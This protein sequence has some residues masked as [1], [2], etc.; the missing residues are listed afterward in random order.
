MEASSTGFAAPDDVALVLHTSGTT[1]RPKI[2]PLTQRNICTSAFHTMTTLQLTAQD[3]CLNVMPLFHIHGLMAAVLATLTAGGTVV[4]SPGFQADQFFMWLD[5]FKPTWYTAVPTMHQMILQ[6]MGLHRE[7]MNNSSLRLIRSSSASLPVRVMK[8]LEDAFRAPVI[9]AYGMTEAAH[10]IASNPLP[11]QARKPGSVGIA[12]GPEVA[13]M[14]EL[15]NLL[16]AELTGE[17]VI[18]GINVTLGYENNPTANQAAFTNEWFRTG[19]QGVMDEDGYLRITGRIK[20]MINRGGEKVMPREVDEALLDHANVAQ[21]VAFAVPHPSLGEDLAAAV[22]LR[23]QSAGTTEKELRDYAFSRLTDFKVPSQILI[24]DEI[25]KGP[26]G[27]LQ[28]IGLADRLAT[29]LTKDYV[30]PTKVIQQDLA[31]IWGRVLGRDPIGIHNNFFALGGDSL[32]AAAVMAETSKQIG[33][34]L[35]PSMLFRAPTIEQLAQLIQDRAIDTDSYLV[36]IRLTGARKPLFLV[37]GHGGDVFTYVNMVRYLHPELPVYVFRFPDPARLDDKVANH[38]LWDMATLYIRE[39][40]KVQPEGPYHIGGFCYGGELAFEMAQQL[41]AQGQ[42]TAYLAII[43]VYLQ[44]SI[45]AS[46]LR[47]RL[48]HHIGLFMRRNLRGKAVYAAKVAIHVFERVSR[49]FAPR[50]TRHLVPPPA[51]RTYFPRYY[52]G[53]F[54]LF[55]PTDDR[56]EGVTYSSDMGWTGLA[57]EINTYEIPGTRY[58]IFREPDVKALAK[59]INESLDHVKRQ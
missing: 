37:P 48:A 2:V 16:P 41:R 8:S 56:V 57:A 30:A 29:N 51:D 18:R 15:G 24:V 36:P 22:V 26:T 5:E 1:S 34:K 35:Q 28:R 9:E 52:P 39:M 17:I 12:A 50:V 55:Q 10:Q 40:R 6:A 43:F 25:P 4:C 31:E 19:D 14:D 46:G 42:T 53:A 38:M 47:E 23:D 49:R 58:T 13:I 59:T 21:A 54:T 32:M 33:R 3:R 27:K 45:H 20:E 11:P 44:G 7:V